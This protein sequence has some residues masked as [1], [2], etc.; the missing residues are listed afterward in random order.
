MALSMPRSVTR[1][2]NRDQ[3][4]QRAAPSVFQLPAKL[5]SKSIAAAES[6]AFYV[7]VIK[8]KNSR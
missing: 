6:D 8:L 3:T 4:R 7:T 5:C 2:S 1:S